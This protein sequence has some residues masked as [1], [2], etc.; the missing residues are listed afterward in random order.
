MLVLSIFVTAEI[1]GRRGKEEETFSG[2]F[3][4]G[5]EVSLFSSGSSSSSSGT[6]VISGRF[7]L[8]DGGL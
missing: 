7:F 8:F 3:A 1:L 6:S 5:G 4:E 2:T